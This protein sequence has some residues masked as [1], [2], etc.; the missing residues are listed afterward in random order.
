MESKTNWTKATTNPSEALAGLVSCLNAGYNAWIEIRENGQQ[1]IP[2]KVKNP[3]LDNPFNWRS[4][5]GVIRPQAEKNEYFNETEKELTEKW[6]EVFGDYEAFVKYK[7]TGEISEGLILLETDSSCEKRVRFP[8]RIEDANRY[9]AEF[10][11]DGYKYGYWQNA[12]APN[13]E[14][15][16]PYYIVDD[17]VGFVFTICYNTE[18][19]DMGYALRRV[20]EYLNKFAENYE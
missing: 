12:W 3:E 5:F 2:L 13:P 14:L 16:I 4:S 19:V 10:S 18:P 1:E 15:N 11:G 8:I 7:E 6:I 20:A 17:S 9:R